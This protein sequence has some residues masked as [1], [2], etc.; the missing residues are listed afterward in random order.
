MCPN[1]CSGHGICQSAYQFRKDAEALGIVSNGNTYG[2]IA[3]YYTDANDAQ[4]QMGC[5]CDNGYRGP[6]C[7]LIEC[8]AGDDPLSTLATEQPNQIAR[9]CSG[10]GVCDYSSGQCKCFKG[11]FGERCESQ[12]NFI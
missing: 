10:R 11:Y 5:K 7:S 12:T 4:R 8:P 6:D 9:D 1:S 2:T 3:N